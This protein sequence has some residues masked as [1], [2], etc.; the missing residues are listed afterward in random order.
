MGVGILG[1]REIIKDIGPVRRM[2]VGQRLKSGRKGQSNEGTILRELC[3][4]EKAPQTFV[5]FG[6]HVAEFNCAE[7]VND[8]QG[9]LIDG[10]KNQVEDAAYFLP[11]SI[12]AVCKFLNLDNL[13]FIREAFPELGILSIDVDGNDY[14]FLEALIETKPSVICIEYNAS[15]GLEPVT[16]PY[17]PS[18]DRLKKHPSGWYHGASLTALA[19][20]AAKHGYGLT[21]IAD[22][23]GN[24]FFTR[25]GNL[26]PEAV[27]KPTLLRDQLS[28]KTAAEQW[29]AIKTCEFVSV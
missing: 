16:V 29:E 11:G 10:D 18:F 24:A 25:S 23:G 19:S 28:G 6:F 7:L 17:D 13:G 26:S 8:F 12:K 1:I 9:L 3:I 15:F 2:L 27:W 21:A 22:G 20:L 5:E 14:W 4:K